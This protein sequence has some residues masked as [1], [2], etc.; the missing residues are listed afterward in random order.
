MRIAARCCLTDGDASRSHAASRCRLPH[1]RVRYWPDHEGLR[2][3]YQNANSAADRSY[4]RRVFGFLILAV[5]NS[6]KRRLA[7]LSRAN[8]LGSTGA[9]EEIVTTSWAMLDDNVLYHSHIVTASR[10][11]TAACGAAAHALGRAHR[12]CHLQRSGVFGPEPGDDFRRSPIQLRHAAGVT[13]T[14]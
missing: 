3:R 9:A 10:A 12:K 2:A 7:S 13:A 14:S 4:A 6:M 1:A 5:K 8:R 11:K